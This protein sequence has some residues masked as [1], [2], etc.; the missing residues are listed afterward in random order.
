MFTVALSGVRFFSS[1]GLYPE[2]KI[3]KNEIEIDVSVSQDVPL[4]QLPLFDYE[5]I[6][7][8]LSDSVKKPALLLED[9]LLRI[10]NQL[11]LLYPDTIIKIS[12]KKL[13]P[14]LPGTVAYSCVLWDNTSK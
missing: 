7:Q 12:I 11:E 4:S 8:I 3:L 6:H 9:V 14:P 5:K 10:I 13:N 2:E 1:V